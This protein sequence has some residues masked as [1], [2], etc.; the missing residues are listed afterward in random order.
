[1]ENEQIVQLKPSEILADDNSRF[2]LKKFRIDSLAHSILETGR[3]APIEVEELPKPVNG[4]RY[5]LIS[6]Y[7]RHAAVEQLNATQGAGLSLP[8]IVRSVG[9][10]Q[11][12]L[13]LQ[14][15]ENMERENQSPMDQA[16]AIKKLLDAGV[17]RP[18]IRRLFARPGSGKGA[19]EPASNAWVNITLSLLEL[20]KSIQE[21]IHNGAV[22]FAAAYELGRVPPDR[23]KI[24][25]E[26]A[27][28]EI[29]AQRDREAADERKYIAAESKLL[30]AQSKE[31]EALSAVEQA[32]EDI[33]KAAELEKAAAARLK[34]EQAAPYNTLDEKGKRAQME[35]LK[36]AEADHK[37]A[38]KLIKDGKAAL[39]K[40]EGKAKSA[41]D[42][43]AEKAAK[44]EAARKAIKAKKGTKAVGPKD[45]Q[46]AAKAE[47]VDTGHV[48][49]SLADIRSTLK[50]FGGEGVPPKVARIGGILRRY[51]DGI[52]TFSEMVYSL[53]VVTGESVSKKPAPE[54]E[55]APAT[56]PVA[57]AAKPK[58][59]P[60]ALATA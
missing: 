38:Q 51:F 25:L 23:R 19:P 58:G 37:A 41:A 9:D 31:S 20:P 46:K 33:K 55:S 56:P 48:P 12:R 17:P 13:K 14:L 44:L 35:K 34:E 42:V 11:E 32:K 18:E 4:F 10:A 60:A 43:A 36:A 47:G 28:A 52:G 53:A 22:G 29:E 26:R 59:K 7:Y 5:K 24:V 2:S 3:I 54:P 15:S 40:L 16:V 21:K 39:A 8:A 57:T 1:M 27:E 30:E 45:V 6:G 50:D 49:L